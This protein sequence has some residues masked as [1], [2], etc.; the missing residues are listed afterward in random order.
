[1]STSTQNQETC[2]T[3]RYMVE[4]SKTWRIDVIVRDNKCSDH[5]RHLMLAGH[6]ACDEFREGGVNK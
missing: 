2:W 3:C 5:F 4:C 1:M 6:P